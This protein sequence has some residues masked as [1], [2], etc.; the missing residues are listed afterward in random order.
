MTFDFQTTISTSNMHV[1]NSDGH[2]QKF[3]TPEEILAAF[4]E[5]RKQC[6]IRRIYYQ[7]KLLAAKIDRVNQQ[8]QI[9]ERQINR[10][11]EFRNKNPLEIVATLKEHGFVRDPIETFRDEWRLIQ[12]DEQ[13]EL[14][15][16]P[17]F[18]VNVLLNNESSNNFICF[19]RMS[20]NA[21]TRFITGST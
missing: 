12:L 2:I 21:S 14:S 1:F 9:T 4:F 18:Y 15:Q 16:V 8:L 5:I 3:E 20:V 17:D 6:Y 19:S 11:I 10:S 13:P 7:Q